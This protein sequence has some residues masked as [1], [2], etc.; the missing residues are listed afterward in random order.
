MTESEL[1]PLFVGMV[2]LWVKPQYWDAYGAVMRQWAKE[3]QNM[4][5]ES[6]TACVQHVRKT[7][8]PQGSE[9][10]PTPARIWEAQAAISQEIAKAEPED[11]GLESDPKFQEYE[12]LLEE[13]RRLPASEYNALKSTAELRLKAKLPR[14]K[15]IADICA[16]ALLPG[17]LVRA[18]CEQQ[19]IECP[20]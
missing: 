8:T 19:G 15:T 7:W 20:I 12:R 11:S 6:F 16:R 5:L 18:Y 9:G 17:E 4:S 13:V 10:F 14:D 2:E 3:F 1:K